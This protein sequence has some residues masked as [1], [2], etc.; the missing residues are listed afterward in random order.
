MR[1]KILHKIKT[2]IADWVVDIASEE[3]GEVA[4]GAVSIAE[5]RLRHEYNEYLD[6]LFQDFMRENPKPTGVLQWR[7]NGGEYVLQYQA[8]VHVNGKLCAQWVDVPK[9]LIKD[10]VGMA[11]K[12][13]QKRGNRGG[14]GTNGR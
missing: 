8:Y 4:R 5:Q 3:A 9:V 2:R 10:S 11:T 7:S 13:T 12:K 6:R 14:V 1:I